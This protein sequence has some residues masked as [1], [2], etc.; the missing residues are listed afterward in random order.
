[1]VGG[2]AA[3]AFCRGGAGRPLVWWCSTFVAS[4]FL[5]AEFDCVT[6]SLAFVAAHGVRDEDVDVVAY[7]SSE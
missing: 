7:V 4:G 2:S 6:E 3:E 5:F 1:M